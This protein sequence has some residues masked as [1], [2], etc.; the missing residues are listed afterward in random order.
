MGQKPPPPTPPKKNIVK[1]TSIRKVYYVR[2]RAAV[3]TCE[4]IYNWGGIE[5]FC[6]VDL[7]GGYQEIWDVLYDLFGPPGLQ[8]WRV[9]APAV[10][11]QFSTIPE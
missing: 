1:S 4:K 11:A 7:K 6:L 8:V 5:Q 10:V 9:E 3:K 2:Y